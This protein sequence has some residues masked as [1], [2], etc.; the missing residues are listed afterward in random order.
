MHGQRECQMILSSEV[1]RECRYV[2]RKN[3]GGYVRSDAP[4]VIEPGK[5]APRYV[6]HSF[7]FETKTGKPV[8]H[9]N[10]YRRAWGKPVYIPSTRHIVVGKQWLWQLEKDLLQ[11]K[12]SRQRGRLVDRVLVDFVANFD[13]AYA[14]K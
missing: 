11:L 8:Y 7:R 1:K 5:A 6:G 12:L 3:G 9:P 14:T 13:L 4:I 10:A 2:A